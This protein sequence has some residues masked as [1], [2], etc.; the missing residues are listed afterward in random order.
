MIPRPR[1][2]ALD[3]ADKQRAD[4]SLYQRNRKLALARDGHACRVCGAQFRLETHHVSPRSSFGPKRLAEKHELL[5]G[6]VLRAI[7]TTPEG[8][9]GDVLILKYDDAAGDYVTWKDAV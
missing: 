3:R 4:A 1:P 5:T 2:R 9:D 6:N 8:A 7:A